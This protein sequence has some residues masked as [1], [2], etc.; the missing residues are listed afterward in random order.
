MPGGEPQF[1][2]VGLSNFF[3]L[4]GAPQTIGFQRTA[5]SAGLGNSPTL[6]QTWTDTEGLYFYLGGVPANPTTFA[7]ALPGYLQQMGWPRGPRFLWL[8]NPSDPATQWVG[9]TL[10]LV[11]NAGA[12]QVRTRV[13]FRF[14][15]YVLSVLSGSM[16]ALANAQQ[17]W[18]FAFGAANSLPVALLAAPGGNYPAQSGI[19][20]LPLAGSLAGCWTFSISLPNGGSTPSDFTQLDVGLR[21]FY[22]DKSGDGANGTVRALNLPG[23]L[24]PATGGPLTLYAALDSLQPLTPDRTHFPFI[25]PGGG[26]SPA[27]FGTTFATSRGYGVT[28]APLA[29][30]AAGVPDARL[31]FA[32][33]PLFEGDGEGAP[34]R[35]YLTLH[36][37]FTVGWLDAQGA[38]TSPAGDDAGLYRLLC[39]TTGLEYLGVPAGTAAQLVFVPGQP[40]YT[41]LKVVDDSTTLP[42]S[43]LGTTAWVY[44]TPAAA[45]TITYYSQPEQ[46]PL[47]QA[48]NTSTRAGVIGSVFLDFLPVPVLALPPADGVRCLP[49]APYRG[50][51]AADVLTVQKLEGQAIAPAR[52]KVLRQLH[53]AAWQLAADSPVLAVIPPPTATVGVTPQ[54]IAIG[55]AAGLQTWNWVGLANGTAGAPT[56]DLCFN[57][58]GGALQQALQTNRL[59]LVLANPDVF[60]TCGSVAYQLTAEGC[61]EIAADGAVPATV[62]RAVQT[63]F[64]TAGFPVFR[65]EKLFNA[66]LA[67]ASPGLTADQQ[68]VF[69]RHSGL[70]TPVIADWRFQISPRNWTNDTPELH[71]NALMVFKFNRGRSLR[72]LAGDLGSWVW[73]EAGTLA[74]STTEATR[75]QL[76]A[77][78]ADADLRTSSGDPLSPYAPFKQLI[79]DPNWCGIITFNCDVP[80]STLP[81]PLQA[82]AVGIDP[83]RFYAHHVGFNLTPFGADPGQL[84]FGATSMFGLI[85]Y[86]DPVD[87][88]LTPDTLYAFK[89]LQLTVGF[90]NSAISSFASRVELMVNRLFGATTRLYPTEHG[91]NVITLV[92]E[93][94]SF[95]LANSVARDNSLFHRFPLK[96]SA[97]VAT[98]DPR[99]LAASAP[100]PDA[101]APDKLGYVSIDALVQQSVMTAPWYGL[102]F[103][104]DL[105][106]LGALAGSVGLKLS[107]L[108]A[109]SGGG[110]P[111]QPAVYLGV[112]M[113]GM[114][115]ALGVELPLQGVLSLGFRT[116]QF[117]VYTD[118]QQGRGYTMRFR[119]FALRFLGLSFPPGHNDIYL[120]GNPNQTSGTKLGW[121]AA[122]SADQD[123][124]KKGALSAATRPR[125]SRLSPAP[126]VKEPTRAAPASPIAAS[127]PLS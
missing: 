102:L 24:Q 17:N 28:L 123:D 65:T 126:P 117:L 119:N 22:P 76:Q 70:L 98:P 29:S 10:A 59:F 114:K 6:S 50:V 38:A 34:T 100:V 71:P 101:Q 23:I 66:A 2:R 115:G 73:P 90:R 86:E 84:V 113:P 12:W 15:D 21:Y 7:G 31:V 63:A 89:V 78:F 125:L 43:P 60:A 33:Q 61:A 5:A 92:T 11:Q 97:F 118:P 13:D 20:L 106:T 94:L 99:L 93:T 57:A 96:L 3:W 68:L 37:A 74:G 58:V 55:L 72:D 108:V 79:E 75:A 1:S 120:F 109:W 18:G 47:Y 83:A 80:L 67:A 26:A 35:Y 19:L 110:T 69:Q 52:R 87:Q 25:P 64:A 91:N 82:L 39:G 104:I 45:G 16:I 122:Y 44:P 40:A 30:P 48:P 95:D 107:L 103:E 112:Q 41:D 32:V 85:D 54:G 88:V 46:A 27:A 9:Q 36:G 81:E 124:K 127:A 14:K 111:D 42:L 56:P 51:A 49:L 121:Y 105:G 53:P 77:I 4:A 62:L 116:I 8:Q